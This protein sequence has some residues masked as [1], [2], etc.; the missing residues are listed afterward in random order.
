MAS[1]LPGGVALNDP[2]ETLSRLF[3]CKK[4]KYPY[5]TLPGE[6]LLKDNEDHLRN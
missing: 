2:N 3:Y 4:V 6:A 1:A 5:R